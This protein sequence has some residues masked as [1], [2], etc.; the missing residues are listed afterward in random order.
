MTCVRK[1]NGPYWRA[2]E[3]KAMARRILGPGFRFNETKRQEQRHVKFDVDALLQAIAASVKRPVEDITSLVKLHE[4]DHNRILQATF[5][6]KLQVLAK[7][8]YHTVAKHYEIASE[9]ATLTLLRHYKFTQVPEVLGYS[10][11]A[12]NPVKTE[13][14]L[15]SKVPGRRLSEV[16][17]DL[18]D[19]AKEK[20]AI[21][22]VRLE[23][24][25]MGLKFPAS[26]S[27][28]FK[29]DLPE[30]TETYNRKRATDTRDPIVVGPSAQRD[31][32]TGFRAQLH[33]HRGPW[34]KFRKAATAPAI[35]EMVVCKKHAIPLKTRQRWLR[36][37]YQ[38]QQ[39]EPKHYVE[40]LKQYMRLSSV[41]SVASTHFLAR[42]TL[43]HPNLSPENILVDPQTPGEITGL[44]DWQGA[45]ILP[46]GL[47]A[48]LPPHSQQCKDPNPHQ[49]N[50][51]ESTLP[52]TWD[53]LNNSLQESKRHGG[54]QY[55]SP[56]QYMTLSRDMNRSHFRALKNSGA[57]I[58][59]R[60]YRHASKP[61][62]GGLLDLQYALVHASS[63]WRSLQSSRLF[64]LLDRGNRPVAARLNREIMHSF[65]KYPCP[66][67]YSEEE[68]ER[69][70]AFREAEAKRNLLADRKKR[71][72]GVGRGGWVRDFQH[73]RQA[74]TLAWRINRGLKLDGS[75]D[76]DFK[77]R[78]P[79]DKGSEE[80]ESPSEDPQQ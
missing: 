80:P 50:N 14:L 55:I 13:Y 61:W 12:N 46:L 17:P 33:V 63:N 59:P 5:N 18:D 34:L 11:D 45:E 42:R 1:R 67:Q 79:A 52:E 56:Q 21:Q 3:S 22:I 4:G 47:C 60:L 70:Q 64:G 51:P 78:N 10:A 72:M 38:F 37:L 25:I 27:L 36:E 2:A 30:G 9:A 77:R 68:F 16:W 71:A 32:W 7:I 44:I 8:P 24:D 76:E 48:G 43:R 15:M 49:L 62:D 19:E 6:D 41:I 53:F 31:W 28:Y 66:L 26:G 40:L 35:R 73:L 69:I 23:A 39:F 65:L 20:V 57:M 75:E 54:E 58:R 29:N 74:R